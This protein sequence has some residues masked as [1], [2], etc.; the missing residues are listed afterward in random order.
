ME[1][2]P[3]STTTHKQ[4][5]ICDICH[6]QI[7]GSKQISIWYNRIEHWVHLRCTSIRLAQYTDTWTFHLHKQSRLTTHTYITRPPPSRPWSNRPNVS[8]LKPKLNHLIH[9]PPTRSQAKRI[10]ISYT[11]TNSF[12]PT[13]HTLIAKTSVVLDTT[14]I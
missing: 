11:T 9:S 12:H 2:N 1:T 14:H 6:K 13:H 3:G 7:H 4:F 10:H 5:W 8:L